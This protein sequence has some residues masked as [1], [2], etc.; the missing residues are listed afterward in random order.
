MEYAKAKAAEL[1]ARAEY[2][3]GSD[4]EEAMRQAAFLEDGIASGSISA[5]NMPVI[6][7]LLARDLEAAIEAAGT[8]EAVASF[9]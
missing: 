2:A 8:T 3:T 6:E 9:R 7:E 1:R 4:L 5:F